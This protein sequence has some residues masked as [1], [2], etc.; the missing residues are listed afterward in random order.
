[1]HQCEFRSHGVFKLQ[2]YTGQFFY[3]T[4]LSGKQ[5][6]RNRI[7]E[8]ATDVKPHDTSAGNEQNQMPLCEQ[9]CNK[10]MAI[11][12]DMVSPIKHWCKSLTNP[13]LELRINKLFC[14]SS[15]TSQL[16]NVVQA[17]SFFFYPLSLKKVTFGQAIH[18]NTESNLSA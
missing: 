9:L 8:K 18:F 5:R 15:F 7:V 17:S 14:N 2:I 12:L 6:K 1:M 11:F 10:Y 16:G 4:F 13:Q 3:A